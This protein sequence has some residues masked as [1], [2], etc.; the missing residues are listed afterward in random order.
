MDQVRAL[1]DHPLTARQVLLLSRWRQSSQTAP[2][3]RSGFDSASLDTGTV[4]RRARAGRRNGYLMTTC[5]GSD[6]VEP[7]ALV[8]TA[9]R[10]WVPAATP[11]TVTWGD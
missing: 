11:D 1:L 2:L 5:I 8:S 4:Q 10:L 6:C 7:F 9:H 3:N